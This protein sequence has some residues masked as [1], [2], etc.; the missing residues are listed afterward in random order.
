[1]IYD[2]SNALYPE[3]V[4]IESAAGDNVVAQ[5]NT[6]EAA[7]IYEVDTHSSD[8]ILESL[9][10]NVSGTTR[11]VDVAIVPA[12]GTYADATYDIASALSVAAG[13]PVGLPATVLPQLLQPGDKIYAVASGAGMTMRG[14]VGMQQRVQRTPG[15]C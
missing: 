9:A 10:F 12:G 15:C 13:A 2:G 4:A 8:Q 3:K 7:L 14:F 6:D 1:M 5:N 11:T